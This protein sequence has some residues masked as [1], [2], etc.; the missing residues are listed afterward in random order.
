VL[1]GGLGY[2]L[3]RRRPSSVRFCV[4]YCCPVVALDP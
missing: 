1:G 4:S 2:K 3:F